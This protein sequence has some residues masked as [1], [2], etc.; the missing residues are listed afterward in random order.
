[1]ISINSVTYSQ[2]TTDGVV[3]NP[4][5][6][7]NDNWLFLEQ[8]WFP[9]NKQHADFSD[10][11]NMFIRARSGL[12]AQSYILDACPVDVHREGDIIVVPLEFYV[13]VPRDD[14][15]Y[16]LTSNVAEEFS[17]TD[18][19][20]GSFVD[21]GVGYIPKGYTTAFTMTDQL[22]FNHRIADLSFWWES[23]V[24]N[25]WGSRI[26]GPSSSHVN[27]ATSLDDIRELIASGVSFQMSPAQLAARGR[28]IVAGEDIFGVVR[29]KYRAIARLHKLELRLQPQ[30]GNDFKNIRPTVIASWVVEGVTKT[31]TLTLDIPQCVYDA[32][33]VCPDGGISTIL[34]IN[35][36]KDKY[37][38]YYSTCDGS[39]LGVREAGSFK[40]DYRKAIR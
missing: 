17:D 16:E 18:K 24:Y 13:F 28:Y 12:S 40:K 34:L 5:D 38:V 3:V 21:D 23:S 27:R 33:Q 9:P 32:I 35:P 22:S 25:V 19:I 1:M 29:L 10:V 4:D 15:E 11:Y 20:K 2:P 14:F 37:I 26:A 8:E 6:P 30:A 39:F 31:Q 36:F 7:Y